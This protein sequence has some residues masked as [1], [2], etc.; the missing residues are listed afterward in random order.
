MSAPFAI[1]HFT[2]PGQSAS[3]LQGVVS[4]RVSF[5]LNS[6]FFSLFRL[7][8]AAGFSLFAGSSPS[9]NATN[10]AVPKSIWLAIKIVSS[11]LSIAGYVMFRIL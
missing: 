4:L 11:F 1:V 10:P 8:S 2:L 3:S 7:S 6:R 9:A 5:T